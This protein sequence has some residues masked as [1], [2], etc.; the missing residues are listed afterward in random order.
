MGDVFCRGCGEPWDGYHMR[1][2]MIWDIVNNM[3]EDFCK[4]FKPAELFES[5]THAKMVRGFLKAEG[6]EFAGSIFAIAHCPCCPA[7]R[8]GPAARW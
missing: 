8:G 7:S 4:K 2:D 5:G 3:G 6:W 1:N